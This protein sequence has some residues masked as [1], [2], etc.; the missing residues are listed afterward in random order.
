ML[1]FSQSTRTA[2]TAIMSDFKF[3]YL[4]CFIRL[5][6]AGNLSLPRVT[7][8]GSRMSGI[9][10]ETSNRASHYYW[11]RPVLPRN[12]LR[13]PM[14]ST[15]K[16]SRVALDSDCTTN[17]SAEID[18]MTSRITPSRVKQRTRPRPLS[19]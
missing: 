7:H 9:H 5:I 14:S 8:P 10:D 12:I 1:L 18:P 11:N 2:S 15:S 19:T 17:D 13:S 6:I 3:E 16:I 4:P